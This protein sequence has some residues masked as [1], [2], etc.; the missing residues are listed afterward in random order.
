MLKMVD[1]LFFMGAGAGAGG[2]N[3]SRKK[4]TVSAAL[5]TQQIVCLV[6]SDNL[7]QLP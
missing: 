2:K 1:S 3:R 7:I 4:W 5:E 6:R